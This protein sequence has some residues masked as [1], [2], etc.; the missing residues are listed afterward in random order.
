MNSRKKFHVD[1]D[2][3]PGHVTAVLRQLSPFVGDVRTQLLQDLATS[4]H[5]I[6]PHYLFWNLKVLRALGLTDMDEKTE[7]WRLTKRG[8]Y[9]RALAEYNPQTFYDMMHYLYY[10]SWNFGDQETASFSWTYQTVCNLLWD[11]RP[12]V[13]NGKVLAAEVRDRAQSELLAT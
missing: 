9:L 13:I 1:H 7:S 6:N 10:A 3:R 5:T 11:R 2:V 12:T 8:V 4:G